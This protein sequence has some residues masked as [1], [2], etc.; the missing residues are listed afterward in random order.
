MSI[1]TLSNLGVNEEDNAEY[2]EQFILCA[3]NALQQQIE[4]GIDRSKSSQLLDNKLIIE[5]GLRL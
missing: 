2:L 1:L 4:E 3:Q 5:V